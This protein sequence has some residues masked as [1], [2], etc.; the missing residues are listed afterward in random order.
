[1]AYVPYITHIHAHTHSTSCPWK[2]HLVDI[3]GATGAKITYVLYPD[4]VDAVPYM[5][6]VPYITHTH[7][8]T[9]TH[10]IITYVL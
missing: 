3:E 8:H 9:H 4:Q 7:T 5:A 1:M 6:Y 2:D 10:G